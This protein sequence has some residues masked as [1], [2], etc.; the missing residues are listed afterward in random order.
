MAEQDEDK[1]VDSDVPKELG[2]YIIESQI[3]QGGMGSVYKATHQTLERP[4][5]LKFLPKEFSTDPEYVSRFLRE[6]R[7]VATL[8]HEN[9]VQVYDAGAEN[10]KY[11]IAMEYIEG[12]SL[13]D[14]LEK[15]NKLS[16]KDGLELLLQAA[17]GLAAA[18]EMGLVHRDIKPDN[19]LLSK[20]QKTLRIVDFGLVMECASKT[21]LTTTGAQ[22]GTPQFM[23][24]E[25]TDGE[26]ADA[27]TDLYSLGATFFY[28]FTGKLPFEATTVMNQLFKHKFEAPPD[29][30][31]VNSK[32]S[33]N[34]G[35][36]LLTLLAKARKD[37]PKS[38][39]A[40][41][42]LIEDI[43]AG[44]EIPE[45]A[46]FK[47]PLASDVQAFKDGDYPANSPLAAF[48]DAA[49]S[50]ARGGTTK[51][52]N[53]QEGGGRPVI[54]GGIVG[55]VLIA[56]VGAF[57]FFG[58]GNDDEGQTTSRSQG[59][60]EKSGGNDSDSSKNNGADGGRKD[61]DT[62]KTANKGLSKPKPNLVLDLGS[63]TTMEMVL[64]KSGT[65]HMGSPDAERDRDEHEVRHQVTITKPFYMG[66][67][68]VTQAQYEA[69]M[70]A[71]LNS[72]KFRAARNP[73]DGVSW[74]DAQEFCRLLSTRLKRTVRLPTEAEWEYACRAG[75]ETPFH[76][77]DLITSD[78][79]NFD[80]DTRYGDGPKSEDRGKTIPVGSFQ[81]NAWGLYD[82]HGNVW[83]F[84][85]DWYGPI[86]KRPAT[87][88]EGPRAG[89]RRVQRG[90]SWDSKAKHCRSAH[91]DH[92]NPGDRSSKYGFRVVVNVD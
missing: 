56:L 34:V 24:P 64:V 41:V 88:P 79:A 23:S 13:G 70:T 68:E 69:V 87:D 35:N 38:A 8:R 71:E 77:G 42:Q 75:T 81:P 90:G 55:L 5:A 2:S 54:A 89:E 7:V 52:I 60:E 51:L 28:V 72:S 85:V 14:Y 10:D 19:L 50:V 59:A 4:A 86:K 76:F 29:P 67:Y 46:P 44:K 21:R 32:L 91:R 57:F 11:Y 25:Q 47:S 58:N 45:P 6:A 74:Q 43:K 30:C 12:S 62:G 82:M 65:F 73:V 15:K 1:S 80:G 83:E 53:M 16:E 9:V 20:D 31:S 39:E 78:L 49:K 18:H 27:R 37:R 22:M 48:V 26:E 17:K 66:K 40:L 92:D 63:G 36:L 61:E 33:R 3:G 84:C